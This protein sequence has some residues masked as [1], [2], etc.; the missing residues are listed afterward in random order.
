MKIEIVQGAFLPVIY[1]IYDDSNAGNE[2][3][4]FF[5][6]KYLEW[7]F[8]EKFNVKV[9]LMSIEDTY[10]TQLE[11]ALVEIEYHPIKLSQDPDYPFVHSFRDLGRIPINTL[12]D[13]LNDFICFDVDINQ[14][15]D[16]EEFKTTTK[17]IK[18]RK[19]L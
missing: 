10:G 19:K 12:E 5:K 1:S 6:N 7:D 18:N 13:G 8:E 17:I 11:Y 3:S 14:L 2:Y 15:I 4:P 9:G 16:P